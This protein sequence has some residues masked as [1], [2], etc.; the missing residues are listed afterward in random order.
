MYLPRLLERASERDY[1][2][3][4]VINLQPLVEMADKQRSGVLG[5]MHQALMPFRNSAVAERTS[6]S[7]FAPCD[8]G[9]RLS[10]AALRELSS[11]TLPSPG[12][13]GPA[14]VRRFSFRTRSPGLSTGAGRGWGGRPS[15]RATPVLA[16]HRIPK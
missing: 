4:C 7:D 11:F 3:I 14:P 6:G 16:G 13:L 9:G 2:R 15:S 12:P 1:P 10:A 5:T 8:L